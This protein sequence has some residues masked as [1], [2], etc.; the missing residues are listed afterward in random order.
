MTGLGGHVET[1]KCR[2][3]KRL[4]K[5]REETNNIEKETEKKKMQN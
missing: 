1:S 5:T 3:Q 4:N 2:N